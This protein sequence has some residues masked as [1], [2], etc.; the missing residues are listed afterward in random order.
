MQNN[1]NQ[2]QNLLSQVSNHINQINVIIIKMNNLINEINNPINSPMINQ[3]NN[4]MNSMNNCMNFGNQIN[5]NNYIDY[6]SKE[7]KIILN[8]T[9][10]YNE[11]ISVVQ[12]EGNETINE[13]INLYLQ[14]INLSYLI[15]NY[16]DIFFFYYDS[17]CLERLKDKKVKDILQNG[18]CI[19]VIK[20]K[21]LF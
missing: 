3:M 10:N 18:S 12:M 16:E 6:P 8:I 13:L 15:N 20:K 1:L 17:E 14:K 5:Y 2:L 9:F 21:T 19:K 11:T 4:L 7:N